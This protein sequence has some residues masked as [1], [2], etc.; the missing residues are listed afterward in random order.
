VLDVDISLFYVPERELAPNYCPSIEL[1]QKQ[2]PWGDFDAPYGGQDSK[3]WGIRPGR[4]LKVTGCKNEAV[5]DSQCLTP[6]AMKA[7]FPGQVCACLCIFHGA[8]AVKR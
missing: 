7:A 6:D 1:T 3:E 8:T 4:E 2:N 5:D